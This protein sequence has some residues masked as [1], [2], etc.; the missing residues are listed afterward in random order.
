MEHEH[1]ARVHADP[2]GA[3]ADRGNRTRRRRR[4]A[5]LRLLRL[6][7]A[8]KPGS[9]AGIELDELSTL[10]S[11]TTPVGITVFDYGPDRVQVTQVDDVDAFVAAHRP[12]WAAVRWINIDSVSNLHVIRALAEKYNLHPLSIEDVL[13]TTHRPKV[14]PYPEEGR[15]QSRLFII[16]RMLELADGHLRSEQIS[17]FLGHKTVL[18]F[19]ETPGDAWD[20]VRQR[21]Q[22]PR[23]RLRSG[24]ASFLV[25]S[26]LD[27]IVD[28]CFPILEHFGDRLEDVEGE[29]LERAV[30][31]SLRDIHHLKRELLLLRRAIWPMRD[32]VSS[33]MREQHECLGDQTR[34]YMRDIYDHLVQIIDIVETY[35]E[36]ATGLTETYMTAMSN[37][38]NEVMKVL[39]MIGTIFIPL[40]FLAGVYGMNFEYLPE[41]R[42][43]WGYPAFW[44][45][46]VTTAV[47]MIAWFRKKRWF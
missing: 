23:S 35:R 30:P 40:T 1:E 38:L 44:G 45:I 27:A 21:L 32:V 20:G 36:V 6:R 28:A 15:Y 19:Q 41:L 13:H 46:S 3:H 37:R 9:V 34:T 2:Q 11:T 12:D 42:R 31:G 24:D 22:A 8:K 39:T 33:L 25:H 18:T 17:I 16:V 26:L 47:V 29:V 43:R 4:S 14:E 5:L 10:P 7:R